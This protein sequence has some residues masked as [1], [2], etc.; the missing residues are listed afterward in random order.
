MRILTDSCVRGLKPRAHQSKPGSFIPYR[1][2]DAHSR[3]LHIQVTQ[4][5]RKNWVLSYSFA[6]KRRYHRIG[7]YP[8]TSI[9]EARR[10]SA[11]LWTDIEAGKDPSVVPEAEAEAATVDDMAKAYLAD[12]ELRGVRTIRAIRYLL[13]LPELSRLMTMLAR[14]VR[15]EDIRGALKPIVD[16][17]ARSHA[18][19][20]RQMLR[21]MFQFALHADYSLDHEGTVFGLSM[22]PVIAVPAPVVVPVAEH[23]P[24]LEE[25]ALA[26]IHAREWAEPPVAM[27]IQMHLAAC[28][29]R[30]SEV[31]S[32]RWD[33]LQEINGVQ[34]VFLP[35]TKVGNPHVIPVGS[36]MGQV[37]EAA[38]EYAG[39]CDVLF[40]QR[41]STRRPVS[42][43]SMSHAHRR[44]RKGLKMT[45]WSLKEVRRAVKTIL[46]DAGIS[47]EM[48]DQIQNHGQRA[49]ISQRHYD[50]AIYLTNKELA[51][52]KW[53][54]LLASEIARIQRGRLRLA[55]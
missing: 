31:S 50:R 52:S 34:C 22:N 4:N 21:A 43:N 24:T 8:A 38:R 44:M 14:D 9:A 41:W 16:R 53:D 12:C 13:A 17:G 11:E 42:F 28:G 19:H 10:R 23:F 32:I 55:A 5:G 40:P 2:F 33:Q 47:L 18:K 29:Q 45:P 26:F 1:E 48:R 35:R 37:I 54:E 20:V 46:G 49:T 36:H 39:D 7:T 27:A 30:V 15:P 3:G 25:I 6:G 51:M